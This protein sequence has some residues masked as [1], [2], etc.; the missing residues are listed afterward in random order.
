MS[1][2]CVSVTAMITVLYKYILRDWSGVISQ[3]KLKAVTFVQFVFH[4][5]VSLHFFVW[6]NGAEK[7]RCP[8]SLKGIRMN[9]V[10]KGCLSVV[11]QR[12]FLSI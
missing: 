2:T 11:Y 7:N 6:Q 10:P 4:G 5:T 9:L 12:I 3:E 1:A 8:Q